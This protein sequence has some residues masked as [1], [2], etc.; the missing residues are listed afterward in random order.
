MTPII[1]AVQGFE[2]NQAACGFSYRRRLGRS[3]AS[4]ASLAQAAELAHAQAKG[5][6]AGQL[7]GA[8][9]QAHVARYRQSGTGFA[10]A[11]G[12]E[13]VLIEQ[14]LRIDAMTA[15]GIGQAMNKA[16]R[17]IA[18]AHRLRLHGYNQRFSKRAPWALPSAKCWPLLLRKLCPALP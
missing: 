8:V 10:Q 2:S 15:H 17:Q 12:V 16:H 18:Q 6:V 3:D 14:W 13:A 4:K 7:N 5:R 9:A 11:P 1:G